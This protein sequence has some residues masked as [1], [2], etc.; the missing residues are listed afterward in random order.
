MQIQ[1]ILFDEVSIQIS[2]FE[3]ADRNE[4]GMKIITCVLNPLMLKEETA[5]LIDSAEQLVVAWERLYRMTT[6]PVPPPS[7][8]R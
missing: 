8:P 5:D 1:S 2:Y 7:S 3:E 6:I 4:A